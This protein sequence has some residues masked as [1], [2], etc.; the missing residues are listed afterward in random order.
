[1]VVV[2]VVVV[3]VVVVVEVAEVGMGV[4]VGAGAAV[5][6]ASEGSSSKS[7]VGAHAPIWPLASEGRSN[8]CIH[9][10]AKYR[11]LKHSSLTAPWPGREP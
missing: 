10:M 1:M 9:A 11:S 8:L 7:R 4:K 3:V 6:A 5:V 2:A